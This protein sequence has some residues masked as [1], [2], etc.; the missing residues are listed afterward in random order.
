MSLGPEIIIKMKPPHPTILKVSCGCY[1]YGVGLKLQVTR[2]VRW[3]AS[4]PKLKMMVGLHGSTL[5][6]PWWNLGVW[7]MLKRMTKTTPITL[8]GPQVWDTHTTSMELLPT[9]LYILICDAGKLWSCSEKSWLFTP[10]FDATTVHCMFDH[11]SRASS[12]PSQSKTAVKEQSLYVG[13]VGW[14]QPFWKQR[15]RHAL[16]VAWP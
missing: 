12:S 3:C 14:T 4:F 1:S 5:R 16:L 8:N 10:R 9:S 11:S 6:A 15:A 7:G 2:P 13:L